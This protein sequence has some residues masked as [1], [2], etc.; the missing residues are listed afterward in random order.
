[1]EVL[2]NINLNIYPG[3]KLAIVGPT[4]SGKSTIAELIL[5]FYDPTEG[6]VSIDGHDL[7]E[8]SIHSFRKQIGVVPQ[9]P[10]LMKGS[11]GTNIAY[12]LTDI[13]TQDELDS[14]IE[15]AAKIAGIHE[16]IQSLP[17]KYNSHVGERG[18]TLSGGQRQRIAIARAI[19]RNPRILIL[20]EATSSLDL[21]VERQVQEAMN[22]AMKGRTSIVIAHRLTTVHNSDRI[23]V[24][25]AGRLTEEGKH[26]ALMHHGK[27]YSSLYKLQFEGK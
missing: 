27:L 9:D 23:I 13:E 17:E 14:K 8:L 26:E 5:R 10:V 25:D 18:V 3:E 2:N 7:R 21:N 1:M 6:S 12:G 22:A 4:G 15:E 19:I 16:F 20:D 11:L 24:L